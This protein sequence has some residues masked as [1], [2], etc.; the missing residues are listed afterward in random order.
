MAVAAVSFG[1]R[2][3]QAVRAGPPHC[4]GPSGFLAVLASGGVRTNSPSAQTCAALIHLRL[5]SSAEHRGGPTRTA[6]RAPVLTKRVVFSATI[7]REKQGS[8]Q[9]LRSLHRMPNDHVHVGGWFA[10]GRLIESPASTGAKSGSGPHMFEWNAVERVC[11]DPAFREEHRE[12]RRTGG[13]S[14]PKANRPP[15]PRAH[16][17]SRPAFSSKPRT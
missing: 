7:R 17:A 13:F 8:F 4:T 11:A 5:R 3:R 10:L 6:Y 9:S 15:S 14:R 1:K 12:V 16:T 2:A